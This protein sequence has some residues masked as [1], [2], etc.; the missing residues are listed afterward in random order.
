[1][2]LF[3]LFA[4]LGLETGDFEKGVTKATKKGNSFASTLGG[5]F[6]SITAK[7]VALGNAMYDVSKTLAQASVDA[8]KSIVNEYAETEQ[9]L[10]GIE[11]I[12][13][14]SAGTVI[15]NADEAF[16]TAGM[17]ANEY[18]Q[19]V[20]GFSSSLLQG[21]GGDTEKAAAIADMA[22]Q[23]M[24]DN[25]NKFGTDI[26]MIQNAYQGFAKDNF[27]MLDNLKLGYGGTQ[28]EM[29]RLINDSGV[30]GDTIV[31]A[32]TVAQVP[33]DKM[34]EAIHII[35]TEMDITGT[36][37]KEASETIAG[38]FNAFTAA[39]KNTISGMGSD[40]DM[41]K[42]IDDLF[43]TG[44][45]LV[46]NVM[47]LLPRIWDN[48]VESVDSLLDRWDLFHTLKKAYSEGGWKGIWDEA[49]NVLKSA[50]AEWGPLAF[51]TASG[52]LSQILSGITGDT[53]TA[54][55]IKTT[56]SGLFS[57]GIAASGSFVESAKSVIGEFYAGLTGEE[58]TAEN[59]RNFF[60]GLF[61][62]GQTA[63][64]TFRNDTLG[65]I[66]GVYEGMT[67]DTSSAQSIS[68]LLGGLFAAGSQ[69]ILSLKEEANGLL[70]SIYNV[71]TGQEA[72]ATNIGNTIGGVF[73]AGIEA[74][75]DVLSTATTFF[76]DV[77]DVLGNPDASLLEKVGG[78]F[79]AGT[80]AAAS[81]LTTS[82]TYMSDL[83]AALTKDKEG[84]ENIKRIWDDIFSLPKL[85]LDPEGS[86]EPTY[87]G[88][89]AYDDV[90]EYDYRAM[91]QTMRADPYAYGITEAMAEEWLEILMRRGPGDDVYGQAL[92][93]IVDAYDSAEDDDD[94]SSKDDNESLITA[95]NDLRTTIDSLPAAIAASMSG[96]SVG[97]D[98]GPLLGYLSAGLARNAR[99]AQ[100]TG[101]ANA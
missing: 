84:A 47:N 52:V 68:N 58:M 24:S 39:W 16:R 86:L 63:L 51:D 27:T 59:V 22:I 18:M 10:G 93:D 87:Q 82:T 29:A 19:T 80:T 54:D 7:A 89:N 45:D 26:G 38:S 92:R 88:S 35:Q 81:L 77:S 11:T 96:V 78:I 13:K 100:F 21:L 17:S 36:T 41:D 72:T 53:L 71:L 83:Y 95:V 20:T 4:S 56:L 98:G 6:Q 57:Q 69:A 50:F 34:F 8:V 64:A 42:L 62:D 5:S 75:K 49:T 61:T 31:D 1:M 73:S 25:A 66:A 48:V 12:F 9:L 85:I 28:A 99:Q 15:A 44:E 70:G 76:S 37:A 94:M 55:Q 65:L 46:T 43:E 79:G 74:S 33:L 67:S 90:W 30:L 40:K 97:I 23:D 2:K 91:V 101:S 3:E 32:S 14:S 60:G